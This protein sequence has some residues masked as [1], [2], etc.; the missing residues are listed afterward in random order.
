MGMFTRL[1]LRNPFQVAL[2]AICLPI[3]ARCRVQFTVCPL[4]SDRPLH[5]LH[6]LHPSHPL[7]PLH[8]LHLLHPSHP[9]HPATRRLSPR[10]PPARAPY[11]TTVY[12]RPPVSPGGGA[13]RRRSAPRAR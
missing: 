8:P 6:L 9:L 5:P 12:R 13:G 4:P 10:A 3:S 2:A 7:H 1:T 11:A